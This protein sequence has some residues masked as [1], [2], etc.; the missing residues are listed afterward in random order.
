M[1][2]WCLIFLTA[3]FSGF[4]GVDISGLSS[5]T[6]ELDSIS[7][8]EG[9]FLLLESVKIGMVILLQSV[10]GSQLTLCPGSWSRGS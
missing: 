7:L 1:A 6:Q 2:I 10:R 4:L 8:A 3:L 5:M 9:I